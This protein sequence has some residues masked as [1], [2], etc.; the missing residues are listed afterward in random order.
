MATS[1]ETYYIGKIDLVYRLVDEEG[2][3]LGRE[4][5]GVECEGESLYTQW[6]GGGYLFK[7][8]T[9]RRRMRLASKG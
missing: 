7:A 1:K 2:V 3:G 8:E 5:E 6:G 9:L 4:G